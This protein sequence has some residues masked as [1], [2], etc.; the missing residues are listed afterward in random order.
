M[1]DKCCRKFFKF[2]SDPVLLVFRLAK[3]KRI[4]AVS[5]AA[6]GAAERQQS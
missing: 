2:S 6:L 1:S 3:K 4:A 5:A